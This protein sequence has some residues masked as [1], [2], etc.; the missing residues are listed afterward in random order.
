MGEG[1]GMILKELPDSYQEELV[2]SLQ[3]AGTKSAW[4]W[5]ALLPPCCLGAEATLYTNAD[6]A[7][8]GLIIPCRAYY[9]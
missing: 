8:V 3:A 6:G 7:A 5:S 4:S 9:F 2:H 1:R